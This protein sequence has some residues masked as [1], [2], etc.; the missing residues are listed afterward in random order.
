MFFKHY[1]VLCQVLEC[2]PK[3]TLLKEIIEEIKI[4]YNQSKLDK[5]NVEKEV[6][7]HE[8]DKGLKEDEGAATKKGFESTEDWRLSYKKVKDKIK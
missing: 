8:M 2:P 4:D 1:L 7:A 6:G 5:L 3:W